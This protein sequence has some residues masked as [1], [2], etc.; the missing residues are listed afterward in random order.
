MSPK[1][2]ESVFLVKSYNEEDKQVTKKMYESKHSF[3]NMHERMFIDGRV[4]YLK[5]FQLSTEDVWVQSNLKKKEDVVNND[6]RY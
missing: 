5:V 2:L 4:S 6:N 1:L 3:E